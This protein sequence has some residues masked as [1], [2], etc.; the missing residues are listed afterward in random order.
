MAWLGVG[1]LFLGGV[2][3][4]VPFFLVGIF[5]GLGWGVVMPLLTAIV[6][7]ISHP[8]FRALNTNL[9]MVV[10]QAGFF[11]GPLL[12]GAVLLHWG[13]GVM[14]VASGIILF[15]TMALPLLIKRRRTPLPDPACD[16]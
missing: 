11:L 12:G 8:R 2:S 7:D 9:T 5:L 4:R 3:S 14:Y 6:F 16:R 1:F 13:H 15:I 10:F